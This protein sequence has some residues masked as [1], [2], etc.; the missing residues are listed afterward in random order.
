VFDFL[1][2]TSLIDCTAEGLRAVG[3]DAVR[4]ARAEALDG[5]ARSIAVR[6]NPGQDA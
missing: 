1:K 2:R 6:L 4:M 3:F 5:H